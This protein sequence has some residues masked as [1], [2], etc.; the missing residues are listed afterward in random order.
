VAIEEK[1]EDKADL[2]FGRIIHFLS[3]ICPL[4]APSF[5]LKREFKYYESKWTQQRFPLFLPRKYRRLLIHKKFLIW[6]VLKFN[7][8]ILRPYKN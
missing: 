4:P 8:S 5:Y 3:E 1:E 7:L 2:N 6:F